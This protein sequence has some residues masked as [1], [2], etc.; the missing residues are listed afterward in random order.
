MAGADGRMYRA[1]AEIRKGN[2]IA[3]RAPEVASPRTVRYAW[4]AYPGDANIFTREGY[5]LGPFRTDSPF[6]P[7]R[8]PASAFDK[9][10]PQ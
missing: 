7:G 5:P 8:N 10:T 1:Q 4:N 3:V 2:R 9:N 6:L